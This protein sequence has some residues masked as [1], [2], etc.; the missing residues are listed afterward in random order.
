MPVRLAL[1]AAVWAVAWVVMFLLDGHVDLANLA[2]VLVLA[3]ASAALWLP[4]G[5]SLASSA[6]A[7]LAFNWN[8]VPPRG[9]FAVDLHQHALLLSAMLAVTWIVATIMALQRITADRARRHAMHVDQLRNLGDALRDV[10]D[11]IACATTLQAA[12]ADVVGAP[13]VLLLLKG[14]MPESNDA[15][16]AVIVGT[17]S[18]DQYTG[19]WLCA[20]HSTPF[21]PGTGRHAELSEWYVPLRGREKSFGAA[22]T[23]LAEPATV[24]LSLRT[25][26]Q[27]LCD[28][29][30]LA[31]ERALTARTA[32]AAREE[33]QTQSVRNAMLAAISHDYRT[34]L[35]TI[36]GAASSLVEQG[37][38]MDTG[39]RQR[40]A[41]T[42]VE[43]SAQLSRLADNT[44][45]LAR[46]DSPG[47][48]LHVDWESA[49]EIVG[50]ALR[51]ARHHDPDRRI[52]ARL[53]PELPL[54]RCDALLLAQLLDNLIDNALKY[55][56]APSPVE[57]LVRRQ[58]KHVVFAVRDRGRGV[59]LAWR[60]RIFDVFQR[61]GS[62]ESA[63]APVPARGA[64]VGLAVCRAIA[65]AHGG[66]LKLRA[67][68]HGGSSFEC[69][70]PEVEPP[71]IEPEATGDHP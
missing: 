23:M 18:A 33:A 56:N 71:R 6:M 11:P 17:P 60:E 10:D 50:T 29:M 15:D 42:I 65:R 55:S 35:A 16:S 3:G 63:S 53:E 31:L 22:V 19:L 1:G 43:E 48:H 40:L 69:W 13:V 68:S 58:G 67:R 46:L 12:L 4:V 39:Q 20:R 62:G 37:E 9:T 61:G 32:S 7:V 52:R 57:V 30:G 66:E 5:V 27:A 34:P 8:F 44:L 14:S 47:V 45:Q 36:M 51:R 2:M 38:R 41:Q 54:V 21:G 26:A 59:P 70:L 49:E 24:D 64:G 28:Q 25:Q